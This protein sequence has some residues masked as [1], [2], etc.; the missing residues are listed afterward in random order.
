MKFFEKSKGSKG[1]IFASFSPF[2]CFR[3]PQ[4]LLTAAVFIAALVFASCKNAADDLPPPPPEP[5][6]IITPKSKSILPGAKIEFTAKMTVESETTTV[7]DGTNFKIGGA[8]SGGTAIS[9]NT[10][11][12]ASEEDADK[13]TV[14]ATYDGITATATVNV[15]AKPQ[16]VSV[17]G[18][19]K[20][21]LGITTA[22]K[23][24]VTD[25]FTALHE[26]IQ[27]GGLT[28]KNTSGMIELGDW[29]DLE[30]RL[31]VDPSAQ[32]EAETETLT[33][34]QM[35]KI[36]LSF[37]KEDDKP[38]LRLIVV[39]IN[40]FQSKE[41]ED[42]Y[43]YQGEGTPPP[44][45][46]FQFAGLPGTHRMNWIESTLQS[47]WE[48]GTNAG[49]Y[50]ASE[51]YSYVTGNFFTGLKNAGVPEGVLWAPTRTVSTSWTAVG[52]LSDPL[53]LPTEREMFETL[54]YNTAQ[55]ETAANQARLE[56]YTTPELRKKSDASYWLASV[57]YSN[58]TN[59]AVV[60]KTGTSDGAYST[61]SYGVAPAF[62]VQ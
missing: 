48:T 19:I 25:T 23:T 12:V 40:S 56:Y 46:V 20:E 52:P 54:Q 8:H 47:G 17:E 18:S 24:A 49:G 22:G 32:V 50:A 30:D 15:F 1:K 45:V 14:T 36:D 26:F 55:G 7:T 28:D 6:L 5:K 35:G 34:A 3:Y 43:K 59:F 10:L 60:T 44:H 58:N 29:I 42:A 62:C 53:W 61:S 27:A 9:K 39:G 57:I 31:Q 41:D 37:S 2:A 51:M 4:A 33:E 13:L 11:T 21:K 38:K 16:N